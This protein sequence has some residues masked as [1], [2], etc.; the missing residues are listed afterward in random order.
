MSGK[1]KVEVIPGEKY[2]RL[3]VIKEVETRVMPN[4]RN[5]R[6][7]LCKCDCD[8]KEVVVSLRSMRQGST[9]SCGCVAKETISKIKKKKNKYKNN[10][11]GTVTGF[12][13]K[14]EEFYLDEEDLS[15]I[16]YY[17]WGITNQGYVS[18]VDPVTGKNLR[19]HRFI[20]DC[21]ENMIVDHINRNPLDNRK[22]NL[23]ICTYSDNCKNLSVY[24]SN[25]SGII[26][27]YFDK[28]INKWRATI[29]VNGKRK[30]LGAFSTKEE[31]AKVRYDA[32]LKYFKEFS[33]NY[34]KL[35]QQQSN[36]QSQHNT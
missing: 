22:E 2:G 6:Y 32:E 35:T 31:A 25:K 13:A 18:S 36:Q 20:M 29:T 26:G 5:E 3:T 10:G 27:V 24:K 23:R 15:K 21:P 14:G 28:G 12:T 16:E 33:P 34:Q 11:D 7:V 4:G 30:W 1:R 19:L 9:T 8:G 17:C